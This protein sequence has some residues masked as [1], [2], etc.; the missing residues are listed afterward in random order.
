MA[1]K[2]QTFVKGVTV[3]KDAIIN[4]LKDLETIVYAIKTGE[5]EDGKKFFTITIDNY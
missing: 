3:N 1:R 5:Y 4:C 2:R